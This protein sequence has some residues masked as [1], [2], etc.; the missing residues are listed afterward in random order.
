MEG[1]SPKVSYE[2]NGNAYGKLYYLIDDIYHDWATLVKTIRNLQTKKDV[3]GLQKKCGAC[4]CVIV[5]CKLGGYC[6]SPS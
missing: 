3:S 4:I 6:S 2:I 5:C 1:T